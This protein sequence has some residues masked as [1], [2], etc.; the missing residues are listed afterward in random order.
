M[1][2]LEYHNGLKLRNDYPMPDIPAGEALIKVKMAGLC[3]TDVEITMGYM[4]FEGILGHEFVGTVVEINHK[5]QSMLGQR[6]TGE[7]NCACNNCEYCAKGLQTHCP[8]RSVLGILKRNGCFAEYIT[9]PIEN[10]FI[11]PDNVSN[12]E[13]V[14][15]E[16][17]A[18]AF[19]IL[20]QITVKQEDRILVLGDGKLGLLIAL[21]LNLSKG[22]VTLAGKHADKL[23]IAQKQGV[24]TIL[25]TE[26]TEE[27]YDIVVEATGKA[28]GFE[29]AQR[30]TRPR[31][32]IVLKST[33]A[34]DKALNLAP[35]V[36]DE[37]T[38]VGS[39]CGPFA[40]ALKALSDKAIDVKPL[41]SETYSFDS[42]LKAFDTAKQ[43]GI[44]KVLMDF[45]V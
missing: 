29:A 38:V 25:F 7:I 35:L 10:L 16:P 30:L 14:F 24:D 28:E 34:A 8:N 27:K 1:K 3:N 15:A 2:A 6:V 13:A 42:A 18:A 41:I 44:L 17:L 4:G 31:G 37:I 12:E 19:E 40:P 36:I 5:D 26:L 9:L 32:T 20:E 39:R 33:V 22:K 43:R 45:T 23:A 21:T 11:V